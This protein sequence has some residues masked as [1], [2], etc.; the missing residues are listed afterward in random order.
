MSWFITAEVV[1]KGGVVMVDK[2]GQ[3]NSRRH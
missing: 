2:R 3:V 1:I